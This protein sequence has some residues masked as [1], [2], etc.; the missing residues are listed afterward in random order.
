VK[1]QKSLKNILFVSVVVLAVA[2]IALFVIM[3]TDKKIDIGTDR[4]FMW[5]SGIIDE[6][7]TTAQ[8]TQFSPV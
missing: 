2:I 6:E 4:Q 5:N 8:L 1:K 7:K 3:G